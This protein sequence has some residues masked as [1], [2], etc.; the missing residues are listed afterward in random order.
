MVCG[1]GGGRRKGPLFSCYLFVNLQQYSSAIDYQFQTTNIR[2]RF[3]VAA[4][5][6]ASEWRRFVFLAV[7][8]SF[9]F[10]G[11]HYWPCLLPCAVV[12]LIAIVTRAA[13]ASCAPRLPSSYLLRLFVLVGV[14]VVVDPPG[15]HSVSL[16]LRTCLSSNAI[17][18]SWWTTSDGVK[19][20]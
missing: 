6:T 4:C 8:L 19:L 7:S 16:N 12:F 11:F 10:S 1:G 9:I 18:E 13:V 17:L 3:V 2:I 15:F 20:F 14:Q 5:F